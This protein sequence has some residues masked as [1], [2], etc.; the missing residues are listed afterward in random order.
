MFKL[1]IYPKP[2]TYNTYKLVWVTNYKRSINIVLAHR[3]L[4]KFFLISNNNN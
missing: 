2:N 4:I 3:M 1:P